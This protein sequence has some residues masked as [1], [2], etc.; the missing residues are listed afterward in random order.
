MGHPLLGD[1]IPF[2]PA[3]VT[4]KELVWGPEALRTVNVVARTGQ[5][6][7]RAGSASSGG[8][9]CKL[10][11]WSLKGVVGTLGTQPGR[12]LRIIWE[13]AGPNCK[14]ESSTENACRSPTL[15]MEA[16]AS[17]SRVFI[18]RNFGS[19][20]CKGSNRPCCSA[21]STRDRS[22]EGIEG[23]VKDLFFAAP[24]RNLMTQSCFPT[25]FPS[26]GSW[27]AVIAAT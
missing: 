15:L 10:T 1:G 19:T 13:S 5:S 23:G 21:V 18:E 9:A 14:H 3:S 6:K 22:Q 4:D 11:T 16:S 20:V 12:A 26:T 7:A 8:N 17:R 24:L 25:D 2:L 27:L